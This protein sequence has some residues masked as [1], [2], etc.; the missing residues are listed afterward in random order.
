MRREELYLADILDAANAIE[1]FL[2]DI[3]KDSFINNDL[4]R[5]AVLQKLT[6][7]GEAA[8][9]LPKTF[10]DRHKEIEWVD[11]VAFCNLAVHAYFSIDCSIVWTTA[12]Q[13][14]P[15]LKHKIIA[16]ASMADQ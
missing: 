6:L 4:V 7:I 12:I 11:I 1:K 9:R 8:E 3:D 16:I 13:D 15:E 14:V 10:K 5:S 2:T